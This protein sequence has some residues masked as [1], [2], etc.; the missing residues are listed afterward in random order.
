MNVLQFTILLIFILASGLTRAA[1]QILTPDGVAPSSQNG[2]F[3]GVNLI[4]GSGIVGFAG[5]TSVEMT[6]I[7]QGSAG[8]GWASASTDPN[9]TL[10]YTWRV[11]Q[12]VCGLVLWQGVG[13]VG[14]KDF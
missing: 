7:H 14:V 11:P 3:P 9:P 2:Q 8:F 12:E 10:T 5:Q 1:T 4:D 6:S 13:A